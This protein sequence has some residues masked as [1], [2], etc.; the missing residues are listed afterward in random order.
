MPAKISVVIPVYNECENVQRI[1]QEAAE[2]MKKENLYDWEVLFMDNHSTDGSYDQIEKLSKEDPRIR[3]I[4]LSRN[5]GYQT[6]ILT[7]YLHAKGDAVV[8]LDADGE[9][10][11]A[12]ISSFLRYWE[13]GFKVVYGIRKSREESALLSF[14][15]KF[16]YRI[17]QSVASI[18][19]PMDAGDFRLLDR[20]VVTELKT[21][22]EANAYLRGLISYI[23]FDQI[24]I[25]YN[26]RKRYSGESKFSYWEYLKLAV[27]GVTSFSRKPLMI[28][29]WLGLMISGLSFCAVIFYIWFHFF[30]GTRLPG[31]TTLI[32]VQFFLAGV[33]LMSIGL[34]G[35]YIGRIFDE[36]KSRPQGIIETM[37]P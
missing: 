3:V 1:Y 26:R 25:P 6:N 13:K 2:L 18:N 30:I 37:T 9:D 15:R 14:Q 21:F 32:L 17:L 10:D 5:F 29:A 28:C 22:K 7:G 4:R 36:V 8:Q 24:G 16:F 33:Q 11:P 20:C 27:D 34:M 23:G 12:L 35:T 31:F 19:L